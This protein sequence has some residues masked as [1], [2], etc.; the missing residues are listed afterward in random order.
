[1]VVSI[2]LYLSKALAPRFKVFI[3]KK[4][5]KLFRVLVLWGMN[6]LY[7]SECTGNSDCS[8]IVEGR[9]MCLSGHGCALCNADEDC[10]SSSFPYCDITPG[11]AMAGTCVECLSSSDCLMEKP[12]CYIK[13]P[14]YLHQCVGKSN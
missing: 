12:V 10:T 7:I 3:T 14:T 6:L 5:K 9:K 8:H 11:D 4:S 2:S 1:M 13:S